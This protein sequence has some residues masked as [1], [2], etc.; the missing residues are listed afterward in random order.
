MY[1]HKVLISILNDAFEVVRE[2]EV[3]NGIGKP[4]STPIPQ[5]PFFKDGMVWFYLNVSDELAFVR[6]TVK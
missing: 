3:V 4:F 5:R 1:D 6:L 2:T